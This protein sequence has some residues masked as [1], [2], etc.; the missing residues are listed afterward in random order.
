[1]TS[2]K[3]ILSAALLLLGGCGGDGDSPQAS[4]NIMAPLAGDA[5]EVL[6]KDDGQTTVS[7]KGAVIDP[8]GLQLT[9]ESVVATGQGCEAPMSINSQALTFTVDNAKPELCFYRYTVKNHPAQASQAK[10]SEANSYVLKSASAGSLLPPLSEITQVGIPISIDIT[11]VTGYTLDSDVVVLGNGSAVVDTTSS[12]SIITYTPNAQGVT[13]LVYTMTS[14]DG[15]DMITGTIDVA[16]SDVGNTAPDVA[17]VELTTQPDGSGHYDINQPYTIDLS[18]Y[19]SDADGDDVQLILVKAWNANVTLTAPDDPSNLSFT[20]QTNMQGSHYVTYAVSDHRGGYSVE[21]VRIETYDLSSTATWH[22]IQKGAKLFSA[23]LTQ[24]EALVSEVPFV[25]SHVDSNGS[26]VATFSFEQAQALCKSKGHLPTS[27]NL[28]EL[29]GFEGG[30]AAKGWPVDIAFW[31]NDG[32]TPALINLATGVPATE[33]ASGHYVTCLNEGGFTID[34]AASNFE[35]VA[36][37]AEKATVTVTL[38]FDGNPVEGQLVEASTTNTNVTFDSTTGTTDSSGATSFVLSSLVAEVVPVS[39]TY[40][41]E[42]LTQDVTFVADEATSTLSLKVTKDGASDSNEVEAT[43][44]DINTNPLV[45]RSVAFESDA[46]SS[47]TITPDPETDASGKQKAS[48]V[49]NGSPLTADVVVN[50]TAKYTP[51]STG[52]EISDIAAVTFTSMMPTICGGAVNDTDKLNA[53]GNCLKVATD[54]SGNWFTS[55][56]SIAVMDAL[57][58]STGTATSDSADNDGKTYA[59]PYIENS[60]KGPVGSFASFRQDGRGVL[61]VASGGNGTNGQLDR[62]CQ[63]LAS[64]E[65]G[66]K[67]TWRRATRTELEELYK[68]KGNLWDNFG[69]PVSLSFWSSTLNASNHFNRV[70]FSDGFVSSQTPDA[71]GYAS[72]VAP[73]ITVCGTGVDDTSLSNS[74]GSCLKVAT[75]GSGNWF[76]S[77]PSLAVLDTLGYTK[78]Y[79]SDNTGKTYSRLFTSKAPSGPEGKFAGFTQVGQ[80]VVKPGEGNDASAGVGGQAYRWCQNL[81]SMNFA[82]KNMW[83]L[84]TK[85]ELEAFRNANGGS[86]WTSHGWYTGYH[87][88]TTISGSGDDYTNVSLSSGGTQDGA[89]EFSYST[90]CIS[91]NP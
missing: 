84:P 82:G 51:L 17:P 58:Y 31:A 9:L 59:N 29:V 78:D 41:G 4:N 69:W 90:A 49:W 50:V 89:P 13:R 8:Q 85:T 26:N 6:S 53:T 60:T 77:T 81:A 1:M 79:S 45:G 65:F 46:G 73:P 3:L 22:D 14:D 36:N 57:G 63:N 64:I 83:R 44:V 75:D 2:R 62:W 10:V 42:T 28:V 54:G 5:F 52:T 21:Q 43:M 72:C 55:T 40:A 32:G 39:I 24:S 80:G 70:R 66:G 15:M 91:E 11:A 74:T 33:S 87:W 86:L 19:V 25:S 37:G 67:N 20:F 48:L 34:A 68:D 47:V 7:L 16:V 56:P 88:S 35:A 27:A 30:P 61:D 12:P 18:G 71:K 23:P 38:T 76:T